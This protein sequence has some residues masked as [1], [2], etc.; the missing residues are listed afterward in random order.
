MAYT[1]KYRIK[2][3]RARWR[4]WRRSLDNK[5][6]PDSTK[7]TIFEEKAIRLW[8]LCL[9]DKN[10]KLAYNSLGIRQL[11]KDHLFLIFKPGG[12]SD[13]IITIMD[14]TD[15]RKSVFEIHIPNKHATDVCNYFDTEL[16]KRMKEVEN[17]KRVILVDDIDR[18]IS[19]E[20]KSVDKNKIDESVKKGNNTGK[21]SNFA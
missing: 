6:S 1:V 16:E 10:T 11:E 8:R 13:Y 4:G 15:E 12:N 7:L 20:E 21:A 19:Q 5:I 18:L 3:L 2:R 9:K 17:A 14:I